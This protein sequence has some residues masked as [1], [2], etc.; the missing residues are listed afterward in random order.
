MLDLNFFS[1]CVIAVW[2]GLSEDSA[3]YFKSRARF[4]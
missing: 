2:N 3:Q 4:N 1:E